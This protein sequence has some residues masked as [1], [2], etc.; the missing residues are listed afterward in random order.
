MEHVRPPPDLEPS[1]ADVWALGCLLYQLATLVSPWKTASIKDPSYINY[2]ADRR[3][4]YGHH[5]HN[6]T[7]EVQKLILRALAPHPKNR[8]VFLLHSPSFI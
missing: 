5:G 1:A 6:L 4:I 7:P 3:W 8:S 2:L